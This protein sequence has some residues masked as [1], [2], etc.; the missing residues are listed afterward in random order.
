VGEELFPT[1]AAPGAFIGHILDGRYEVLARLG[2]GGS[3][4]VYRGK[5][6]QLGRFVAIKVLERHTAAVHEWRRRFQREAKALSE[7]AHPNIVSVT[8]SGIDGD[9]P[10]LVMEL[11]EGKTL[12]DLLDEGR[13]P[14]ARTLD[15]AR[16]MLRGLAFARDPWKEPTP[17]ALAPIHDIFGAE[18]L[19]AVAEARERRG[20]D[21]D[22]LARLDRLKE[23][24]SH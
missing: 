5:Q 10:Y 7:L 16:Q 2:T 17:S 11:L 19:P 13:L 22:A 1:V 23:Y 3:G 4:V 8:D 15:I 6:V 14:F 20:G 24:L 18:A 21:R 9:V 12:V